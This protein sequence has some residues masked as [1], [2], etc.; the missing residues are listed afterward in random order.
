MAVLLGKEVTVE[1]NLGGSYAAIEQ[2]ESVRLPEL[3]TEVVELDLL[4]NSDDWP[5]K[6]AAGINVGD[7]EVT[8]AYD[9]SLTNQGALDNAAESL[10]SDPFYVKVTKDSETW[11]YKCV[12]V[13][14]GDVQVAR[15][16]VFKRTYTFRVEGPGTA[17]A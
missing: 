7:L 12:G 15:R 9:P 17:S 3:T 13:N 8:V 10:Q 2:V 11:E 14:A 5:S 4:G 6:Y 16:D 1:T